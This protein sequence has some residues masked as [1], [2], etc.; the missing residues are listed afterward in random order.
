MIIALPR[1]DETCKSQ[2]SAALAEWSLRLA[3]LR[4][5]PLVRLSTEIG[6]EHNGVD[7]ANMS[8]DILSNHCGDDRSIPFAISCPPFWCFMLSSSLSSST[9][10]IWSASTS[11]AVCFSSSSFLYFLRLFFI[12]LAF[13]FLALSIFLAARESSPFSNSSIFSAKMRRAMLWFWDRDRVA[14]DLTTIP[15]GM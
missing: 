15:V 7:M 5:H 13:F 2:E 14:C 9:S 11:V 6:E 4:H 1:E 3:F 10:P 8:I 12:E